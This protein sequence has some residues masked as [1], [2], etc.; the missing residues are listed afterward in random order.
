MKN[1]YR[2]G[3]CLGSSGPKLYYAFV[4]KTST[5]GWYKV[6]YNGEA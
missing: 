6:S 1:I 4:V 5:F 3:V 2:T